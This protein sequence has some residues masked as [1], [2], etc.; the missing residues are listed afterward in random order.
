MCLLAGLGVGSLV[1]LIWWA[2][3]GRHAPPA[4]AQSPR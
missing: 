2:V 4:A 1:A 3:D